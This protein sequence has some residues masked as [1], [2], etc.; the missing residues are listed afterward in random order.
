[1]IW[2]HHL[3][4]RTLRSLLL[5]HRLVEHAHDVG[6]LHDQ[7]LLAIDLD[8]GPRPLAEQH[9]VADLDVDWDKLASLVAA[10]GA[11]SNDLALRGLFLGGVGNNDAAS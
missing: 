3:E 11:D 5:G 7:E 2:F 8:F 1:M 10:A 4:V 9:A 6:L